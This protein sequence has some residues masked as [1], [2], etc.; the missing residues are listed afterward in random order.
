MSLVA[1]EYLRVDFLRA[2]M[3]FGTVVFL[4]V[5][6]MCGLLVRYT[7]TLPAFGRM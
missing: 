4:R 7:K 1:C 5:P 3:F 2:V 6:A